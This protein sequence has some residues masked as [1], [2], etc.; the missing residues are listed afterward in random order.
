MWR[1]RAGMLALVIVCSTA[2]ASNWLS[3]GKNDAGTTE[4]FIDVSSIQIEGNLR[5]AWDK[6]NKLKTHTQ[7]G[8]NGKYLSSTVGK[9]EYNCTEQMTRSHAFTFY[10]E[11]GTNESASAESLPGPWE[12]VVPD[13]EMAV[14]M[15]FIC[16][17]KQ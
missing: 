4:T 10:N 8:P 1:V 12:P 7:K 3:L 16:A 17:W 9:L 6:V 13:T 14:D 5:R 2:Q 11:D 15:K